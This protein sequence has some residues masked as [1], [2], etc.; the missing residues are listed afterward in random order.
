M[1]SW[2]SAIGRFEN[3]RVKPLMRLFF[4]LLFVCYNILTYVSWLSW[5]AIN[6]LTSKTWVRVPGLYNFNIIFLLIFTC[7]AYVDNHHSPSPSSVTRPPGDQTKGL[8]LK[9]TM[10]H[11]PRTTCLHKSQRISM[12]NGPSC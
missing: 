12:L 2:P 1:N 11:S 6:A 3:W 10:Y 7:S 9:S 4:F 8:D 5:Q